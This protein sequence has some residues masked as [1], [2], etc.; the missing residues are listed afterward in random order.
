MKIE[1]LKSKDVFPDPITEI[2]LVPN[3]LDLSVDGMDMTYVAPGNETTVTFDSEVDVEIADISYVVGM[4]DLDSLELTDNKLRIKKQITTSH[5]AA[6]VNVISRN[7]GLK[8]TNLVDVRLSNNVTPTFTNIILNG[9]NGP[10]TSSEI[11]AWNILSLLKADGKNNKLWNNTTLVTSDPAL[12]APSRNS[13]CWASSIDISGIPLGTT[14]FNVWS[15]ANMGCLIAPQ[16][17]IGVGH[18]SSNFRNGIDRN[19]TPGRQVAFKGS[20]GTLHLRTVIASANGLP[21][22]HPTPFSS[23]DFTSSTDSGNAAYADIVIYLLNEPLPATVKPV[24]LLGEWA[25]MNETNLDNSASEAIAKQS[26]L[27]AKEYFGGIAFHINQFRRITPLAFNSYRLSSP[28]VDRVDWNGVSQTMDTLAFNG[29]SFLSARKSDPVW[30]AA[31]SDEADKYA[32]EF[33]DDNP[34]IEPLIS[35]SI[36]SGNFYVSDEFHRHYSTYVVGDSG[37]PILALGDNGDLAY[38]DLVSGGAY[39]LEYRTLPFIEGLIGKMAEWA[40]YTAPI[41]MPQIMSKPVNAVNVV[42]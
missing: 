18:W 37:T 6:R 5:K 35:P 2:S 25:Y 14:L 22:A 13:D 21:F 32:R 19:L 41:D 34:S 31:R 30:D 12:L 26:P 16:V 42:R 11:F 28:V 27:N 20:D 7:K 4:V 36:P 9:F 39:W 3:Q 23:L 40:N 24:K 1:L 33:Y 17:G 29:Y 8:K 15:T 10:V 38:I